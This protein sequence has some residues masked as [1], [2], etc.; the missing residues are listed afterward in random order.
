M[1]LRGRTSGSILGSPRALAAP[2]VPYRPASHDPYARGDLPIWELPMAVTPILRLPVIG[3]S[4]IMAP[5]W[6][7]RRLVGAVL[8]APF[9]NLELHGID[10]A[11]AA[12]DGFPGELVARQPDLRH[13]LTS[14][15]AAL[16]ATL[17]QIRAAGF[18]F[19][20]LGEVAAELER[21]ARAPVGPTDAT[22]PG[23]PG[24]PT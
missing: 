20:P 14:K 23:R 3:T 10:L 5:G 12:G 9:V 7:R 21:V 15:R 11:D 2:S 16:E 1:R 4:V 8:D 19:R 17:L 13:G 6:A 18:A 24:D 22:A